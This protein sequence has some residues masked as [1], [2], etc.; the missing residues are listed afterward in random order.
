MA[1]LSGVRFNPVLKDA[2]ERLRQAGKPPKVALVACMRRLIIT[3][4]AMLHT[5][6]PWA[7][8]Q[9]TAARMAQSR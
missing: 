3:L 1:T 2:Y 9:I 7:L 6:Q 5:R 8:P 4:N